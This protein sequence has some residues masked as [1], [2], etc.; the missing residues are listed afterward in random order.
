MLKVFKLALAVLGLSC[1]IFAQDKPNS[2][3]TNETKSA[4]AS[5]AA[6]KPAADAKS[7]SEERNIRFQF[8]GIPYMDLVERFAQMANK[9]LI[10]ETNVQGSV[11][12]NDPHP[13]NF[14][15][16][17]ETLNTILAMKNVMLVDTDR[18]L[19]LVP[20]KDIPQMPLKI[21]RGLDQTGDV[22]PGEIVTVV[23]ELK[24]LD[25]AESAKATSAML[26]S[27]GSIAPL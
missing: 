22:R 18:Y 8:D 16:A 10:S 21:F 12:F 15:E 9:P 5:A 17:F 25:P 11:T 6:E 3:N 7:A 1:A 24:N 14:A 20:F 2:A 19:R 13:Y 26:S 4:P 27:A 23:M